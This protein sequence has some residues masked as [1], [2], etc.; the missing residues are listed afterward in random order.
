MKVSCQHCLWKASARNLN[1]ENVVVIGE[2]MLKDFETTWPE[3]FFSTISKKL[4][5]MS[6]STKCVKIG[7]FRVYGLNAIYSRVMHY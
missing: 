3:G 4:D 7:N 5:E 2:A 6:A 1:V